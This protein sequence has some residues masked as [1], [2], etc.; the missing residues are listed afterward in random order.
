MKKFSYGDLLALIEKIEPMI[1]G[2]HLQR[3]GLVSAHDFV[4]SLSAKNSNL[5]FSLYPQNPFIDY[6]EDKVK[7]YKPSKASHLYSF[8]CD[9]LE[10]AK[11]SAISHEVGQKV[12]LFRFTKNAD[13]YL[14][15]NYFVI[16]EL[17]VNHP[18]LILCDNNM[19]ILSLLHSSP[20]FS[21]S[22]VLRINQIYQLPF[23]KIP[24][25]SPAEKFSLGEYFQS[26][27]L[28]NEKRILQT[29]NKQI[30]Q[31]IS[32][33]LKRLLSKKSKIQAEI[34][35]LIDPRIANIYGQ[36]LLTYQPIIRGNRVVIEEHEIGVEES[37]TAI[38]NANLWFTRAKKARTSL[39]AKNHQL[40]LIDEEIEYY[41]NLEAMLPNLSSNDVLEVEEELKISS[42]SKK[43]KLQPKSFMPYYVI[44]QGTKIGFGR[45]NLQNDQLTFKI[46]NKTDTFMHMQNTPG[47][48]LLI[49]HPNP[50]PELLEYTA[51]LGLFL[52]KVPSGEFTYAKRKDLSKGHF[53]G[54][55]I[56][57]KSSSI[58]LRN[59]NEF[60]LDMT[61]VRRF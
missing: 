11:I 47:S 56:I 51:K 17:I 25:T 53:P 43:L 41:H 13:N 14:T 60:L 49:F 12:V 35:T 37:M 30:Y 52:A 59:D 44:F 39:E 29:N 32:S 36:L 22:R 16:L 54:S 24:F 55:V 6:F 61:K 23:V 4:F 40:I 48:H 58:F 57:H 31:H 18:N 45:N 15:K 8:L 38:E 28:E 1:I 21:G 34:A 46:A 33:S 9:H 10:G 26:Y 5:I 19:Q 20:D 50:S 2:S 7:L 27:L 3:V 42:G